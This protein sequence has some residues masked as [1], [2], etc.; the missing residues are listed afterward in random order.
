MK[1]VRPFFFFK[2]K[3]IASPALGRKRKGIVRLGGGGHY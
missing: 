1:K 2:K 3:E